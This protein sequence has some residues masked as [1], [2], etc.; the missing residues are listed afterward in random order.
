MKRTLFLL[1]MLVCRD[2]SPVNHSL[3]A[4]TSWLQGKINAVQ[5]PRFLEI[6]K[7]Y[8]ANRGKIFLH[9]ETYT[10]FKKM[11]QAA[12]KE[13]ISL[14]IISGFRSY[15]DQKNIWENK[16][17][18][19]QLVEG[20]NL[21][22]QIKDPLTRALKI[23][24]YSSM[25]TTSRHHWGTDMDLN[26]LNNPYFEV[27][28]EGKKI[29][30]WLKENAPLFGFCQ[31]YTTKGIDRNTGY[32]EEKWHWSY[33]PISEQLTK[34]YLKYINY[35]DITGFKGSEYAEKI[36]I[37]KNYVQGISSSCY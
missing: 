37:I 2:P 6:A 36:G 13:G 3:G 16:W 23:L 9:R 18:G 10:A 8:T 11:Y 34:L 30:Q 27:N 24:N 20:I 25:P 21:K 32:E 28:P 5:D 17:E 31:P 29:Y 22:K 1:L 19:N 12:K 14:M 33:K 26:A 4:D 15:Y 35:K 7:M